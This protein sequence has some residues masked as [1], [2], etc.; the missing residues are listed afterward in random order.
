MGN[1]VGN[2]LRCPFWKLDESVLWFGHGYGDSES[3]IPMY[4]SHS[5][6]VW[7]CGAEVGSPTGCGYGCGDKRRA[8]GRGS[9]GGVVEYWFK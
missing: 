7:G 1:G 9:G 2:V 5:R 4:F 3:G 8:S 6:D